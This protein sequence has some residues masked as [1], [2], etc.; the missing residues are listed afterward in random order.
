MAGNFA[1]FVVAVVVLVVLVL[2]YVFLSSYVLGF[3]ATWIMNS[4]Y[5]NTRTRFKIGAA[6]INFLYGNLIF[7][8]FSVYGLNY[9][10]K[11]VSGIVKVKWWLTNVKKNIS[12]DKINKEMCEGEEMS[13]SSSRVEVQLQGLEFFWFNR[14]WSYI[15]LDRIIQSRK[16]GKENLD[17]VHRS[18]NYYVVPS[19]YKVI[20]QIRSSIIFNHLFLGAKRFSMCMIW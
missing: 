12:S 11:A 3:L 6:S 20:A 10:I 5:R 2:F 8:D 1:L 14:T 9:S 15:L 18:P 13:K 19:F 16:E 7:K 4:L 17:Y